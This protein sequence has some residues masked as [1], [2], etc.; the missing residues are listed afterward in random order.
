M[1]GMSQQDLADR[2]GVGKATVS[3]Y[4]TGASSG[5]RTWPKI[6]RALD[7]PLEYL[8]EGVND[9]WA[10]SEFACRDTSH[11]YEIGSATLIASLR[12]ENAGLRAQVAAL[13]ATIAEMADTQERQEAS[14]REILTQIQ[15]QQRRQPPNANAS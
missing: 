5:A 3:A 14:L 10:A 4:C 7:V 6:A 9:P 8:L 11:P 1:L 2:L 12:A 13:E 15:Q